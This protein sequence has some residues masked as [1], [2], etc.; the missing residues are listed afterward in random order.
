MSRRTFWT[1]DTLFD[2][3]TCFWLHDKHLTYLWRHDTLCDMMTSFLCPDEPF[4][5]MTNTLSSWFGFLY[6]MTNILTP[7]RA[8]WRNDVF[9]ASWRI[10]DVIT[11]TLKSSLIYDIMTIFL[12]DTFFDVCST[13]WNH[14]ESFDV[15][16]VFDNMT[17]VWTPWRYFWRHGVF[18]T[19]WCIVDVLTGFLSSFFIILGTKY[20]ENEFLMSL[21]SWQIFDVMTCFSFHDE[22][23]E[24]MTNTLSSWHTFDILTNLFDVIT[25]FLKSWNVFDL[26]QNVD[27]FLTFWPHDV[28]LTS[29][30]TF[31]CNDKLF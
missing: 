31:V 29:W 11:N 6:I 30:Q 5:V 14:G 10:F 4:E 13:F 12:C 1:H 3:M 23:Y 18:F 24:V 22:L 9:L 27:I 25:N 2:I 16:K 19:S 7:G 26:W 17:N 15:M 20:Y 28:F 21:T 8:F